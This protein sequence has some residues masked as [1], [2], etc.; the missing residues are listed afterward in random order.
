MSEPTL[1]SSREPVRSG[2]VERR[3]SLRFS[4]LEGETFRCLQ[5]LIEGCPGSARVRNLSAGG[6]SLI[7]DRRIEPVPVVKL[8]LL[9]TA[10]QYARKLALHVIYLQEQPNGRWIMGGS[11]AH[12]LKEGE[13]QA[14]LTE[15]S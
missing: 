10:T 14:L 5:G 8:Q 6:V 15:P 2:Q 13:L 7:F 1:P 9:N 3:D 4:P 12:K 11:F